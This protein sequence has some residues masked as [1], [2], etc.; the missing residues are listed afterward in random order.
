MLQGD[1][2]GNSFLALAL[3]SNSG[4]AEFDAL[5]P[6]LSTSYS[7]QPCVALPRSSAP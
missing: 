6:L 5:L 7:A 4:A 1:W 3:L 2:L